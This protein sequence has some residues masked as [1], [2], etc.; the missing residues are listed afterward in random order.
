MELG[1][2]KSMSTKGTVFNNRTTPVIISEEGVM[3]GGMTS[4]EVDLDDPRVVFGLEIGFLSVV[5]PG[6]TAQV[7]ESTG[8][9]SES[10]DSA[11]IA[12]E[13]LEQEDALEPAEA[14]QESE[15]AKPVRRKPSK[16]N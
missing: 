10:L 15:G 12:P 7:A 13:V 5:T 3:L 4:C 14:Q 9:D 8:S 1:K 2:V 16:E 6:T 11:S